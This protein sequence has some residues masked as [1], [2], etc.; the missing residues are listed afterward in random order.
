MP[1]QTPS[2]VGGSDGPSAAH[3]QLLRLE[4]RKPT[5][6]ALALPP[7]PKAVSKRPAI[8]P[9]I[10]LALSTCCPPS[11]RCEGSGWPRIP[12]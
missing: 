10:L 4:L 12:E 2:P 9:P 1:A 5:E 3:Q 7:P 8:I 11:R 6:R